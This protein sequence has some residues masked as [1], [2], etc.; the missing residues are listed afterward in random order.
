MYN[1]PIG[2]IFFNRPDKLKDL[3]KIIKKIEPKELFLIQDGPRIDRK[4]QDIEK[5]N[6]C[7]LVFDDIDWE[8]EVHRNYSEIN[9]GC[10]LRPASGIDWI[11]DKVEQ[12]IILEDDCIPNV[13]FFYFCEELLNKYKN[14][15]QVMLISG[16][17]LLNSFPCKESYFFSQACTIGAWATW[18]RAWKHYDFNMEAFD[19][20][21]TKKILK[22]KFINKNM[23]ISKFSSWDITRRKLKKNEKID[24]WDYQFHMQLFLR[25]GLGIVP[26]Y[27][28]VKN[29]GYG[30]DASNVSDE[31]A[32][33]FNLSINDLSF[34][35]IH[36]SKIICNKEF[37]SILFK[38]QFK[39]VSKIRVLLSYVKRIIQYK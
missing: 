11:F 35:L 3:F 10:G 31:N 24:W 30:D 39:N 38:Q 37:D 27:N 21:K 1:V 7:R 8:C 15:E 29:I 20:K 2:I 5:I 34:P 18:K 4:T 16:M 12:C 17:N 22:K 23:M 32:V 28:L 19:S 33:H 13:S 26:K 14:D 25:D 9:L 6:E 36:P